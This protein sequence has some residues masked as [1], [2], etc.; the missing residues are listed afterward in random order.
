MPNWPTDYDELTT[1]A[2]GDKIP[3]NDVSET[4]VG[5]KIKWWT[6]ANIKAWIRTWMNVLVETSGPTVL[7]VGAVADASRLKRSGTSIVGQTISEANTEQKINTFGIMINGG[8]LL[9]PGSTGWCD[10]GANVYSPVASQAFNGT[11]LEKGEI[12]QSQLFATPTPWDLLTVVAKI[13]FMDVGGNVINSGAVAW[14]AAQGANSV[15]SA[16]ANAGLYGSQVAAKCA[17]NSSATTGLVMTDAVTSMNLQSAKTICFDFYSTVALNAAD[18]SFCLDDTASCA[19]ITKE[20]NMPAISANTWTVVRLAC[21]DMSAAGLAAVI[22]IGLKQLVDKGAM[23]LYIAN[24]C[25]QGDVTVGMK[26]GAAGAGESLDTTAN[27]G[28]IQE[29]TGT[30][31]YYEYTEVTLPTITV[32]NTPASAD[33]LKFE[34]SRKNDA[35]DTHGAGKILILG[36]TV[37]MTR[38]VS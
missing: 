18:F 20:I 36:A 21:G 16:A 23:D 9:T 24:V 3:V 28:T 19:S 15:C 4:T 32:G 14:D 34:I 25:W 38:A 2:D 8:G 37:T 11:L 27:F 35:S 22:S 12:G 10:A 31:L 5:K 26:V 17:L 30:A 7:T 33:M 6:L 1:P 13:R 29:A